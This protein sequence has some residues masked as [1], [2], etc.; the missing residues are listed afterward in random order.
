MDGLSHSVIE[1]LPAFLLEPHP[2]STDEKVLAGE[3][4]QTLMKW[5]YE[6][7][8][9]FDEKDIM[10][11]LTFVRRGLENLVY[12]QTL[13]YEPEKFAAYLET[14]VALKQKLPK[15]MRASIYIEPHV[16][17]NTIGRE[18]IDPRVVKRI[19]NAGLKLRP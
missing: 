11:G 7:K 1:A 16:L 19:T 8:K 14:L 18:I 4:A 17:S 12:K 2:L 5:G 3:A 15:A 9:S 6:P 13:K 10:D